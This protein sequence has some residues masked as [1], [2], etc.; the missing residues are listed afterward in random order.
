MVEEDVHMAPQSL[1]WV[2]QNSVGAWLHHSPM[3]A[4]VH[5]HSNSA[6]PESLQMVAHNFVCTFFLA[7]EELSF[8][9]PSYLIF[10]HRH[11]KSFL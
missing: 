5:H 11:K 2:P 8:Y 9:N 3:F 4:L 7:A 6:A 1:C 10:L